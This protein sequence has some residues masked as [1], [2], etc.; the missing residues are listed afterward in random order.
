VN[1]QPHTHQPEIVRE[2]TSIE[3]GDWQVKY[4]TTRVKLAGADDDPTRW[5]EE[6]R[7]ERVSAAIVR[8]IRIHDEAS[9]GSGKLAEILK[10]ASDQ[11]KQEPGVETSWGSV[12]L[13]RLRLR[14]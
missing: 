9:V 6:K 2:Y 5:P 7:R 10:D 8:A 3:D 4:G 12:V 1:D 14:K 13:E 11:L